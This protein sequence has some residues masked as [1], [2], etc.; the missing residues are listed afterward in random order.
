MAL[1]PRIV[2][3]LRDIVDSFQELEELLDDA[4][5]LRGLHGAA[6]SL[7]RICDY[8][9]AEQSAEQNSAEERAQERWGMFLAE[10]PELAPD[11]LTFTDAEL[12]AALDAAVAE[13][14]ASCERSPWCIGEEIGAHQVA[15]QLRPSPSAS[16][17]GRVNW[18]LRR[19]EQARKLTCLRPRDTRES[20]EWIRAGRE[21]HA[22]KA[23]KDSLA[24][25][26]LPDLTEAD[27]FDALRRAV[28]ARKGAVPF[29]VVHE[30]LVPDAGERDGR[31][32]ARIRYLLVELRR[33]GR[34]ISLKPD[35]PNG[36][37]V[38]TCLEQP[39]G[40]GSSTT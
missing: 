40:R 19:L 31:T 27:V 9:E 5:A 15:R 14:N 8:A 26:V 1:D 16:D 11:P 25:K 6:S 21:E 36:G 17:I 39:L 7:H 29:S 18:G 10:H 22:S 33:S 4:E 28:T 30:R 3:R 12:L 38:W 23:T 37:R 2:D 20:L 35:A 32:N 24:P 34:A 13:R